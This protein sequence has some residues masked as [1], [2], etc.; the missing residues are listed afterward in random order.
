MSNGKQIATSK[1]SHALQRPFSRLRAARIDGRTQNAFF[2]RNELNKLYRTL[3]AHTL[4]I[5]DAIK[6]DSGISLQEAQIEY[7]LSLSAIRDHY[8]TISP[9]SELEKEYDIAN[10][11]SAK[12]RRVG[13]GL[14]HISPSRYTMLYSII[15]PLSAAIAAGNCI[16]LE[17][18]V[19]DTGLVEWSL[20]PQR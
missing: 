1:H 5:Q 8:N 14:V 4:P 19:H 6:K 7:F 10:G 17:V 9:D 20:F 2:R 12:N 3:L 11:N 18:S 16:I 13:H 15:A